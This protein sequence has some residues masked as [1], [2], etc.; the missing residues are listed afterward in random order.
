LFDDP[1]EALGAGIGGVLGQGDQCPVLP[2][3]FL[4]IY[5]YLRVVTCARHCCLERLW[6]G[7]GV[8]RITVVGVAGRS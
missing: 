7:L 6:S 8:T 4:S 3:T 1:V 2:C 5:F